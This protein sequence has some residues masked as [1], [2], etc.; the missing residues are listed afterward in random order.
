MAVFDGVCYS[1][2]PSLSP[3]RRN[4]L[5]AVLDLNGAAPHPPYTHAVVPAA[6]HAH[7]SATSDPTV[8][9][10]TDRWVDRSIVMGK[11]QPEQYYSPDPAMIFSGVVACATDLSVADLEVLSAGITALGGQWRVG[12]TRDVTHLFALRTGSDKYNTALHFAPQTN[13]CILTPHWFDD[14]VRLGRR[15]PETPYTWPDPPVLRPGVTLDVDDDPLATEGKRRRK[16]AADTDAEAGDDTNASNEGEHVRVWAGRRVLLSPSLELA[17]GSRRAIEAR[18]QRAGGVVVPIPEDADEYLEEKAVDESDVLVTRWRSGKSYLKAARASL[19][20][21]TLSWLFSVESSGTLHS[22]LDSLLWYPTPRGGIPDLIDREISI[23]NYTG[24]ARDYLKRLITLVGAKFTPSMSQSNK[25]L[26]AG[27]QPSPKTTRALSWSI[28]VVNHTWLEDCF[29]EWR[30]LTVGLER[31]I[32]YPPGVDFGKILMTSKDGPPTSQ[33]V[34]TQGLSGGGV[35]GGRGIGIIDVEQ[36]ETRD[37]EYRARSRRGSFGLPPP[38]E[39]FANVT[40]DGMSMVMSDVDVLTESRVQPRSRAGSVKKTPSSTR[41]KHSI[42]TPMAVSATGAFID[43]VIELPADDGDEVG[44]RRTSQN[45]KQRVRMTAVNP[46]A[47]PRTA[48]G[49][50]S[51]GLF[52]TAEEVEDPV[53]TS[54]GR[55]KEGHEKDK[56]KGMENNNMGKRVTRPTEEADDEDIPQPAH[57]PKPR[58]RLVQPRSDVQTDDEVEKQALTEMSGP[59]RRATKTMAIR[60]DVDSH[61]DGSGGEESEGSAPPRRPTGAGLVTPV[62]SGMKPR[63]KSKSQS[64]PRSV[65]GGESGDEVVPVAAESGT[66]T[67][68]AKRQEK[69][70]QSGRN[71]SVVTKEKAREKPSAGKGSKKVTARPRPRS[72]TRS[73][74]PTSPDTK[75]LRIPKRRLSVVVPSVPKDYFSSPSMLDAPGDREIRKKGTDA[76]ATSGTTRKQP[77]PAASMH[78]VAAEASTSTNKRGKPSPAKVTVL[79]TASGKSKAKAKPKPGASKETDKTPVDDG[80]DMVEEEGDNAT[81]MIVDA[82]VTSTSRGG[83][84]RSAANKAT[85]RLRDIMPDVVNFEKE[86]KQAKR[87]RSMGGESVASVRGEEEEREERGGKRRKVAAVEDEEEEEAEVEDVVLAPSV[88]AKPKPI[89]GKGKAKAMTVSSDE[90]VMDISTKN[91]PSRSQDKKGARGR[92]KELAAIRLITTGVSL[93]DDVIKR[94]AK[95]G[96]QMTTKPLDCTH[97]IAKGI[98][99]TEKFLCATSVSPH[100]LIEEWAN[101]SAKS[102]KLLPED[103]YLLSDAAAEKKWAFKFADAIARAKRSEGGS[104]LFKQMTFYVTP[105]VSV[106]AKLLK[107]VISAGGGQVQTSTTPTV[108]ILKGKANRYVVSCQEDKAIWRPL[109][110]EGFKIY[111]PELV[112]RGALRQE[113][114]WEREECLVAG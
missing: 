104:N 24:A 30:A 106:D 73:L 89:H 6:T 102:G 17:G 47:K 74:S 48:P 16:P 90:E 1:L 65:L 113:I 54:G 103:D 4:E 52:S 7:N 62:K 87:R 25:V 77:M 78:A 10:V 64:R 42:S 99:R 53:R 97:L 88:K 58:S 60:S 36:E 67:K 3:T 112:L 2:S 45:G 35:P 11:R 69:L 18:I 71:G 72:P 59:R 76:G 32:L 66:A 29:V 33:S 56:E 108:R 110:Q 84:R 85:T 34:P 101:A 81:S 92:G 13:M 50:S 70:A 31:Y 57:P 68:T 55:S 20:I 95:L 41:V 46:R 26:I 15:I 8:K 63:P 61:S 39:A 109:V 107:N 14:A 79:L 9:L 28:P 80:E 100:I 86:Q 12:L 105:K 93:S 83:P 91:K 111:S 23:T 40:T 22:P 37:A 114:E 51:M 44:T 21:G 96:V 75:N 5:A 19:L 43:H 49:T 82:P 38:R 98:V 27:F 94:L